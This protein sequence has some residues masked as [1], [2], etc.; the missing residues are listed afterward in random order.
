MRGRARRSHRRLGNHRRSGP[1][2]PASTTGRGRH[3]RTTGLSPAPRR[4]PAGCGASIV[5]SFPPPLQF[6]PDF[7]ACQHF[8]S[9]AFPFLQ[10]TLCEFLAAG[11]RQSRTLSLWPSG[12][13]PLS[14][15]GVGPK[16]NEHHAF[17]KQDS[18]HSPFEEYILM[19]ASACRSFIFS[20]TQR[21]RKTSKPTVPDEAASHGGRA[22]G[23]AWSSVLNF[24]LALAGAGDRPFHPQFNRLA[25]RW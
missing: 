16:P 5:M 20:Q 7:Q 17:R 8:E 13:S 11:W 12:T 2:W 4:T 22:A 25:R 21:S 18:E 1:A 6:G 24:G 10:R 23:A 3:C 15:T 19:R 9:G 14:S